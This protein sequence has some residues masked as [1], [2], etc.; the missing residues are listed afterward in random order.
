M[1]NKLINQKVALKKV[2]HTNKEILRKI[3][4]KR[5]FLNRMDKQ[6]NICIFSINLPLSH[7]YQSY[8]LE[9]A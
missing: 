9:T 2:K 7:K 3:M 8:I 1:P 5:I 4:I 6:K